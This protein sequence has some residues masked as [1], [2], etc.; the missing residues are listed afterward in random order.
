MTIHLLS[1]DPIESFPYLNVPPGGRDAHGNKR[2]VPARF[3]V[4]IG[5]ITGLTTD[6]ECLII[7]SDLQGNVIEDGQ[8]YLLGEV[9]P[10]FLNLLFEVEFS[11]IDRARTGVLLCGDLYASIEKRGGLGDVK[12]VWRAF[13]KHFAFV[14]GVAGNHDDFGKKAE[15][16]AFQREEGI[17]YLAHH[18][19]KVGDLKIGGLSGVIGSSDKPQRLPEATFLAH[20]KKLLLKQPDVLLLHQGPS[21]LQS[22]REREGYH[23]IRSL[24]ETSP[25]NTVCCGHDFW[26][27][28]LDQY[29]NGTQVLNADSKCFVLRVR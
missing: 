23:A 6:L 20:L 27:Q 15:F 10:D 16:E 29:P 28:S 19:K 26:E 11:T 1:Q 8:A 7:T 4:Y 13:K 2:L 12:A 22:P 5:E 17:H 21:H 9:L 14:A 3:P 24:L 25:R 18:V